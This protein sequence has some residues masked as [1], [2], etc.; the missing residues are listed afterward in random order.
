MKHAG[1]ILLLVFEAFFLNVVVP[2]HTRG[3]V[4]L[5]GTGPDGAGAP[6]ARARCCT[7]HRSPAGNGDRDGR[8]NA[9]T[10]ERQSRCAVC[11]FAAS[12]STPPAFEDLLEPHG[13]CDVAAVPA[14]RGLVARHVLLP[15]DG[16]GP[17]AC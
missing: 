8:D 13:P 11:F 4:T 14:L 1:T 2:A 17:P 16:R 9:P 7:S 10:P 6:Y 12:L 15:Y 3:V 5:P